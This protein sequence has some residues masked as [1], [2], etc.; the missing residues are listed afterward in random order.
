MGSRSSCWTTTP[1]CGTARATSE[2]ERGRPSPPRL[3]LS[4]PGA[5]PVF[6][7]LASAHTQQL[8]PGAVGGTTAAAPSHVGQASPPGPRHSP[9]RGG[10]RR[11]DI[12]SSPHLERTVASGVAASQNFHILQ[13]IQYSLYT[14]Y[15]GTMFSRMSIA[16]VRAT[17][18]CIRAS[19]DPVQ[20]RRWCMEDGAALEIVLGRCVC[21]CVFVYLHVCMCV[22]DSVRVFFFF[23]P[24]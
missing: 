13:C 17:S 20:S 9:L 19:R 4:G 15:T 23:S 14:A 11:H 7:G 24:M 8:S 21:V 5:R 6:P 18:M 12:S 16:I 2:V 10:P 1:E 22:S 3:S